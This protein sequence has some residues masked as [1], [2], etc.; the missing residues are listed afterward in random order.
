[1]LYIT[2]ET[3]T[4]QTKYRY[5]ASKTQQ[6]SEQQWRPEMMPHPCKIN[7]V[8]QK[9]NSAHIVFEQQIMQSFNLLLSN[10]QQKSMI[11]G[12]V[13]NTDGMREMFA[14]RVFS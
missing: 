14:A 11:A 1:M 6:N 5:S 2:R 8:K 13:V 9:G 3:K 7:A 12:F 4:G 10:I